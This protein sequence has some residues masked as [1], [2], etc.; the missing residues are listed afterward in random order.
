[1]GHTKRFASR[2]NYHCNYQGIGDINPYAKGRRA[3]KAEI[4]VPFIGN[5]CFWPIV[6]I[7]CTSHGQTEIGRMIMEGVSNL[8]IGFINTIVKFARALG[9]PGS[10]Y[11]ECFGPL[12]HENFGTRAMATCGDGWSDV[13]MFYIELFSMQT[14]FKGISDGDKLDHDG[15][16]KGM[17]FVRNVNDIKILLGDTGN[18]PRI[19]KCTN[20]H[21]NSGGYIGTRAWSYWWKDGNS[22]WGSHAWN[23][24][25]PYD[26]NA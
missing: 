22:Y 4:S 6:T 12:L 1:M 24:Y 25:D 2:Y 9:A 16:F 13:F 5:V 18:N 3:R 14:G 21:C 17:C 23:S 26:P 11:F 7:T 8:I 20:Q 10:K 19:Y 15:Q